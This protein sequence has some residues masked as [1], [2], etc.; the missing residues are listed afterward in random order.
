MLSK[1]VTCSSHV[2]TP[3]GVTDDRFLPV[4]QLTNLEICRA[5]S[6]GRRESM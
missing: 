2:L 1:S 3:R 5:P 4:Q 6:G